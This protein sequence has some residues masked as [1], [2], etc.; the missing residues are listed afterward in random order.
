[1]APRTS[2]SFRNRISG[3]L[4]PWKMHDTDQQ[5]KTDL[6]R[7]PAGAWGPAWHGDSLVTLPHFRPICLPL[8][9]HIFSDPPRSYVCGGAILV[10]TAS[11]GQGN[12]FTYLCNGEGALTPL[13]L[14]WRA[15]MELLTRQIATA[16]LLSYLAEDPEGGNEGDW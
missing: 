5:R 1:M 7:T 14:P 16:A 11:P 10:D 15:L 8:F 6:T 13:L 3:R 9:F 4:L 2:V 12:L